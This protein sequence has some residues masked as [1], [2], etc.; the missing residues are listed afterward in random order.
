M[1]QH[2]LRAN[3]RMVINLGNGCLDTCLKEGCLLKKQI[4]AHLICVLAVCNLFLIE[5]AKAATVI[6]FEYATAEAGVNT[7]GAPESYTVP[8]GITELIIE[9]RGGDGAGA[10]PSTIVC[11]G[12]GALVRST[13]GVSPGDVLT[14][15]VGKGGFAGTGDS[16]GSKGGWGYGRGGNGDG[17]GGGGGGGG[18]AVLL[19]SSPLIIAGGGGGAARQVLRTGG[20][21]GESD[22]SG[23]SGY[24]SSASG[25]SLGSAGTGGDGGATPWVS[26]GNGGKHKG[27]PHIAGGGGGGGGYG[28]GAGGS[29]FYGGGGGGSMA[30]GTNT[31]FS[32]AP[33]GTL[34]SSSPCVNGIGSDGNQ[35]YGAAGY[36]KITRQA[37]Q[38]EIDL[39]VLVAQEAAAAKREAELVAQK[40]AAAKREADKKLARSEISNKFKRSEKV[41]IEMFERAEITGITE[42]N[43]EAVNAEI[44]ALPEELRADINPVL[45]VARKYEVVGII[46]SER[47]KSIYSNSLIEIGLIPTD[48][49][50]KSSLTRVVK[51]LSQADRSTYASI[52]DA[53][54]KEMA[55]IQARKDRL[56]KVLARI[57]ARRSN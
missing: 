27:A 5:S 10:N 43:I 34:F 39:E 17:Y 25:G 42:E 15:Y 48:S 2:S 44:A 4:S 7:T 49:K 47:V 14:L 28:G 8:V 13:V 23:G 54:E 52:K 6:T 20:N 21:A 12:S 1:S 3:Y 11:G 19:N 56:T 33:Y 29:R 24:Q 41:T 22:G 35:R 55:V 57:A 38:V 18:T 50:N 46:A 36:V 32:A 26:G 9:A 37:S 53:I 31:I 30:V 40:A 45:K 51:E 16:K